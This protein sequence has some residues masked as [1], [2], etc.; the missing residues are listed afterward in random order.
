MF[1]LIFA[2]YCSPGMNSCKITEDET[3]RAR[4]ALY[5]VPAPENNIKDGGH[6][7][8]AGIVAAITPT[9]NGNIQYISIS[10]KLK[11]SHDGANVENTFDLAD[12]S[13]PSKK[14]HVPSSRKPDGVDCFPKL[15]EK[16]K[17]AESSD[18]GESPKV[19]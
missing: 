18:K 12:M 15:K 6:D 17:V 1:I 11:G 16:G 9:L 3:T 19:L 2:T 8:T 14:P 13:K 10:G 5:M 4:R 7:A